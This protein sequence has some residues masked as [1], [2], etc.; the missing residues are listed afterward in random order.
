MALI[1]SAE[2]NDGNV[3]VELRGPLFDILESLAAPSS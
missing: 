3:P 2:A 1:R